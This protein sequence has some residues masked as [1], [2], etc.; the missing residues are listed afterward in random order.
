MADNSGVIAALEK[1]LAG[2]LAANPQYSIHETAFRHVGI[3]G[4]AAA[5]KD[6]GED[7][8]RHAQQAMERL[9]D[10]GAIPSPTLG[11]SAAAPG[12]PVTSIALDVE[13]ELRAEA[14]WS[15]VAEAAEEAGDATTLH[16]A[17]AIRAEESEHLRELRGWQRQIELTGAGNFIST[18]T[19]GA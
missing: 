4:L 5:T 8:H 17:L 6:R 13:A 15:A 2:E 10:L 9:L 3:L 7:E 18:H 14:D 1:A 16:M 11:Q 12:D 19:P